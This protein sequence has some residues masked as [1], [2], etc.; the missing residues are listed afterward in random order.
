MTIYLMDVCRTLRDNRLL[1]LAWQIYHRVYPD[2][3]QMDWKFAAH[4]CGISPS[5]CRQHFIHLRHAA[6][7]PR[8]ME[9]DI[10]NMFAALEDQARI[11]RESGPTVLTR[12]FP[13]AT[14]EMYEQVC[15]DIS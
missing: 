6:R 9:P 15:A 1:I 3:R 7:M 5:K 4:C 2:I 8:R 11:L 14:T 13:S 10:A 12:T